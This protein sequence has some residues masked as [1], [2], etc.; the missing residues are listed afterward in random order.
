MFLNYPNNPT[1]ATVE[2][3]FFKEV[4]DFAS[5]NNIIVCHDAPYSELSFDNYK[6]PSFLEVR[7]AKEIGVEFHS[8]SKTYNMTG[9]RIGFAVGNPEI[10]R[11]LGKVKENIDSGVFQAVQMA[12]IEAFRGPQDQVRKNIKIFEERRDLMVDGLNEIGFNVKKPKATF[13][14]WFR[15]PEKYKSSI[16][17][18]RE[19]FDKAGV[20]MTPGVGFG[21]Y[22]EGYVRCTI[23]QSKG[24]LIE[25][26]KRIKRIGIY[27]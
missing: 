10:L 1:A 8:L 17:F 19:L 3:E 25:A 12:G 5:D 13:Y 11:G 22:G 7:G 27:K 23:T 6:A 9:W 24:R 2:K 15:I 26:L 20:V 21:K 16:E 14:L 4:V 18:C